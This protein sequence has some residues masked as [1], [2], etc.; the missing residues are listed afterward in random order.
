M[1]PDV[2]GGGF[3]YQICSGTENTGIKLESRSSA[4]SSSYSRDSAP[5]RGQL[6]QTAAAAAAAAARTKTA[7]A[8]HVGCS[9]TPALF[10]VSHSLA[11][12]SLIATRS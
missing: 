6:Q 7:S 5:S 1:M 2:T 3:E 9:A 8:E 4:S 12:Q 10:T 11:W